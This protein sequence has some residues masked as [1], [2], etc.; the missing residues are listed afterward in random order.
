M[1]RSPTLKDLHDE[2][3]WLELR[4][5]AVPATRVTDL[6]TTEQSRAEFLE[7]ARMLGF[8]KRAPRNGDGGSGPTPIQLVI[9]DTLAAGK[10]LNA[11][12]EPRRTTKSASITATMVG[13][14]ALRTD[15]SA[16]FT[17]ATAGARASEFFNDEVAKYIR[18]SYPE[19]EKDARP[20]HMVIANGKEHVRWPHASQLRIVPPAEDSFRGKGLDFVWV[21]EAQ[22]ANP[23]LASGLLRGILPTM[24]TKA[25]AQLV[26]SGTAGDYRGG[27]LLWRLL[28]SEDAAVLR[29]NA[30]DD[31]DPDAFE[32][33]E[34]TEAR[35]RG[36]MR[37]LVQ[38]YHPGLGWTTAED[39]IRSDYNLEPSSFPAEYLGIWGSE[40][41]NTALIPQPLWT[42]STLPQGHEDANR[43]APVSSVVVQVSR[44]ADYVSVVRAWNG[45]DNRV[46][47]VLAKHAL[48]LKG[49]APELLAYLRKHN[50]PVSYDTGGAGAAATA[51]LVS[52]LREAS[53][54]PTE[55]P[56]T[57]KDSRRA[58]VYFM[59][60]LREDRLRHYGQLEMDTAAELAVKRNWSTGTG[61]GFGTPKGREDADITPIEAA[62][63]AVYAL[64]D[65][66]EIS[67]TVSIDFFD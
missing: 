34:P 31:T 62:A 38:K 45:A 39:A 46:H 28:E 27:N 32:A 50:R 21:D 42:A 33:W 59:Q 12:L 40:G 36:A 41:S 65:E 11:I 17:F 37:S 30:P 49:F 57:P 48:S 56:L 19:E 9:T 51:N 54:A 13:R 25:G 15:Y 63:L 16:V 24:G 22:A 5:Q 43:S 55:R 1:N 44:D 47:I 20:F 14:C 29:H 52:L 58:S 67:T 26:V 6:V 64:Q 35:P 8:D 2:A 53:P 61:W 66:R 23:D 3:T 4:S 18:L 60:L 7:G 10:R